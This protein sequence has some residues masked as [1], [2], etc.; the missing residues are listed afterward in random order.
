[1]AD[2]DLIIDRLKARVPDLGGRVSGAAEFAALTATGS[3]PQVTPAAHVI[4]SG[5]SGGK[6]NV[7]T[8]AYIQGIERM[9]LVILTLRAADASGSRIL[10]RVSEFIDEIITALVGWELGNRIGVMQ[11]QRCTLARAAAGIFAY[12]LSFSI[13]DQLRIIPS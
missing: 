8:G 6:Q 9:F 12:E 5:I 13:A 1:M 7:Q 2:V 3:A 10:D 4:P 11:F